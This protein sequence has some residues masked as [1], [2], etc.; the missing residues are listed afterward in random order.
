MPRMGLPHELY[1]LLCKLSLFLLIETGVSQGNTSHSLV[2]L[3]GR[4]IKN[5]VYNEVDGDGST[6]PPHDQRR[7]L[8]EQYNTLVQVG[9]RSSN[10]HVSVL[11]ES[12]PTYAMLK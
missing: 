10:D 6:L 5:P 12:T 4:G 1:I 3:E 11:Q 8:T 7:Q 2:Q 9:G